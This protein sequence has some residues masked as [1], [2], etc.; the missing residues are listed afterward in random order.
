MTWDGLWH[1]FDAFPRESG[2]LEAPTEHVKSSCTACARQPRRPLT[3]ARCLARSAL[4]RLHTD[5]QCLGCFQLTMLSKTGPQEAIVG[6]L[7]GHLTSLKS[8]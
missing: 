6:V 3:A 4:S 8:S 7:L 5:A 2:A 1:Q